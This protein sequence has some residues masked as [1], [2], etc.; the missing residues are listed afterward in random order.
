MGRKGRGSI[1]KENVPSLKKSRI[2]P[3]QDDSLSFSTFQRHGFIYSQVPKD[4]EAWRPSRT[5]P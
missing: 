2:A 3:L 5:R 1:P 4:M